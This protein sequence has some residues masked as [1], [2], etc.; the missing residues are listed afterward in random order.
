VAQELEH[1]LREDLRKTGEFG[2]V[3]ILPHS[4]GDVPDDFDAHLVVAPEQTYSRDKDSAA[5]LA[6]KEILESR[7]SAPRLFRN[8]LVFLAADRSAIRIWTK[9]CANTSPGIRSSRKRTPSTS[10]PSNKS[11]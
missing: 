9:R 7:G 2:R 4:G 11:V 3:H 1:Q 8:T 6:A 5:E 10:T